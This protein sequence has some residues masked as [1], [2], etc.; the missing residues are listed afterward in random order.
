[1]GISEAGY[2]RTSALDRGATECAG[3][4][5]PNEWTGPSPSMT[6]A[7]SRAWD[8]HQLPYSARLKVYD[9]RGT[10]LRSL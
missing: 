8:Q 6:M 10:L 5:A 7:S 1:M 9:I 4:R 3:W 2:A